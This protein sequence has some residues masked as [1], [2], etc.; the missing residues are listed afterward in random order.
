MT[1]VSGRRVVIVGGGVIGLSLAYELTD[2]RAQ[3]GE[4]VVVLE[5]G[6]PGREASWAGAGMLAAFDPDRAVDP[7]DRLRGLSSRLLAEWS[8]RLRRDT[9]VDNGYRVCHSLEIARDATAAEELRRHAVDWRRRGRT[10]EEVEDLVA[11][12]PEL[13]PVALAYRRPGEA[14]L[15]N[16]RHLQALV[17]ACALQGVEVRCGQAVSGFDLQGGCIRAAVTPAGRVEGD[18]FVLASGAWSSSLAGPLGVDLR[19]TPVRGQ[20][21]LLR[22]SRPLLRHVVWM[23]ERYLVPRPEGRVLVGSTMEHVGFAAYPTA[24]GVRG[25]LDFAVNTVPHFADAPLERAWAGLRP[26]SGRGRPYLGAAPGIE[27]L[28]LATGH[29]RHG[30]ELSAGTAH[31]LAQHL[32]GETP[33]VAL[34]AFAIDS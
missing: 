34:D 5:R 28:V 13:A 18:V 17:A 19:V 33:E 9:G 15:R 10:V 7:L 21:V 20:I 14:Q 22:P 6:E 25:L 3:R 2:P 24:E 27:N 8:E 12:E 11:L 4:R 30:L 26:G 31:V 23:G 1:S 16:P 32:R 29:G